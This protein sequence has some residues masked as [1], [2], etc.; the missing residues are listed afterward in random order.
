[1]VGVAQQ[2]ELLVVVQAVAG[3]SPV[4]HPQTQTRVRSGTSQES[5]AVPGVVARLGCHA[6]PDTVPKTTAP[7]LARWGPQASKGLNLVAGLLVGSIALKSAHLVREAG[8]IGPGGQ[9]VCCH[10]VV[11]GRLKDVDVRG[12]G[13]GW[14][15]R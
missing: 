6:I 9:G 1:M 14:R 15:G 3:S 4:A 12:K 2:V 8:R 7:G 10:G 13:L 5:S 11:T